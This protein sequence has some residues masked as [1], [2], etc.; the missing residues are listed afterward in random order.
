MRMEDFAP[1]VAHALGLRAPRHARG[2]ILYDL[3]AE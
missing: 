2:T 3:W 1:T